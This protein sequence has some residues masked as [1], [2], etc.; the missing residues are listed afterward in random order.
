L[1]SSVIAPVGLVSV[2][3]QLGA[4]GWI[5]SGHPWPHSSQEPFDRHLT[6]E[7]IP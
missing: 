7:L 4:T 1:Q 2:N 3:V 6:A 5:K